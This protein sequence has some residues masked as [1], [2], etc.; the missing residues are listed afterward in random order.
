MIEDK[1]IGILFTTNNLAYLHTKLSLLDQTK[2]F[3][4]ASDVPS[5]YGDGQDE[6]RFKKS[7]EGIKE[8]IQNLMYSLSRLIWEEAGS[9]NSIQSGTEFSKALKISFSKL[10]SVEV[11]DVYAKEQ[12]KYY[13]GSEIQRIFKLY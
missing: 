13:C 2:F 7:L 8:D 11:K 6:G 12:L 9:H 10:K 3:K 4:I 5:K 1:T